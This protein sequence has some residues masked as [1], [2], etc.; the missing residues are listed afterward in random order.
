MIPMRYVQW[1][2]WKFF[3]K[4]TDDTEEEV[5]KQHADSIEGCTGWGEGAR[6]GA[7]E[8]GSCPRRG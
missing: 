8:G 6:V 2:K 5:N 3:L 7:S 4:L 1:S